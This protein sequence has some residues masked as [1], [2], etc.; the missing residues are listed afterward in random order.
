MDL[1]KIILISK[2]SS[3]LTINTL[4]SIMGIIGIF[5]IITSTV[6]FLIN[7]KRSLPYSYGRWI[8]I[9]NKYNNSIIDKKLFLW[10]NIYYNY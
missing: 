2:N 3:I 1:N 4:V 10:Y 8:F 9:N 5:L 7:S 6:L